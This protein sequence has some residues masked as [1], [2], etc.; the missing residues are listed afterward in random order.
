MATPTTSKSY[1]QNK[2]VTSFASITQRNAHSTSSPYKKDEGII[3]QTTEGIETEEYVYA[4]ANI[5]DSK[6]IVNFSKISNGR[7]RIYLKN[8]TIAEEITT[9]YK[10]INV[11]NIDVPIRPLQLKSKRI[12]IS[13]AC[14]E[15]PH[16]L[17]ETALIKLGLT[18]TSTMIFLRAGLKK[19][20]FEHV[21]SS[22]RCVYVK[23]ETELIPETTT[24]IYEDSEHRIFIADDSTFCTYCKKHG[25]TIEECKFKK[26]NENTENNA[27]NNDQ[28]NET[29]PDSLTQPQPNQPSQQ[30]E[31]QSQ[32]QQTNIQQQPQQQLSQE[33]TQQTSQQSQQW[34][35]QPEHE[36]QQ[37]SQKQPQQHSV[38]P[39]QQSEQQLQK[40]QQQL[41]Q[42]PIQ[43]KSQESSQ[44][45]H[46]QQYQL[47]QEPQKQI[48]Q[49]LPQQAT[50]QPK[51]NQQPENEQNTT[52]EK[53]KIH[54][55]KRTL[56][57]AD[58]TESIE[59]SQTEINPEPQNTP[60][61]QPTEISKNK[62]PTKN[63]R[64]RSLSP[65]TP[66]HEWLLPLKPILKKTL[67]SLT[68]TNFKIS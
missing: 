4:L 3:I 34:H 31:Q 65:G 43:Q 16:S 40:I 59:T 19:P 46:Q 15:I 66:T 10:T 2:Q 26:M 5:T 39:P 9:N 44:Q 29:Q 17:I 64:P 55:Q 12:I 27:N 68:Y 30:K 60:L 54:S 41:P 67:M 21:L 28:N 63:K 23:N 51:L 62:K 6:N 50:Q 1:Q 52:E 49:Q 53:T 57:N 14:P 56:S 48:K 25:H 45:S 58:S 18:P 61:T 7:I 38:N 33:L 11:Q 47:E 8:K 13:N 37:E 20:G 32:Q 22:R 36:S 35:Y 42:Q 24:L